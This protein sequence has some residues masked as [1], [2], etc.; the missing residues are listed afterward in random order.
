MSCIIDINLACLKHMYPSSR[1]F[2]LFA[3]S[4]IMY[5][6]YDGVEHLV[7]P[8]KASLLDSLLDMMKEHF[9]EDAPR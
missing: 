4:L 6:Q 3:S 8:A 1:V 5:L 9:D 2:T 7:I